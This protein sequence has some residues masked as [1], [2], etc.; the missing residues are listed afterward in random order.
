MFMQIFVRLVI[1]RRKYHNLLKFLV[2]E[3]L[4]ISNRTPNAYIYEEKICYK[5][6]RENVQNNDVYELMWPELRPVGT[7]CP[8][9]HF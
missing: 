2:I 3:V 1:S 4:Q 9:L 5:I 6:Y 7:G 8:A